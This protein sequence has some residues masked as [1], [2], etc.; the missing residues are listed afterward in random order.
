MITSSSSHRL[1]N[2]YVSKPIII[3]TYAFAKQAPGENGSSSTSS[4]SSFKWTVLIRSGDEESSC[5]EDKQHDL[6]EFIRR[7]EFN[8]HSTFAQPRRIVESP[9]FQ[10]EEQGWG[11]FEIIAR[12]FFHDTNEKPVDIKHWLKVRPDEHDIQA[13]KLDYTQQPLVHE[14]FEEIVFH[15]PHEWF[16]EKLTKP[17]SHAPL[18]SLDTAG[19]KT[20]MSRH[21]L[22]QWFKSVKEWKQEEEEMAKKLIEIDN[23]TRIQIANHQSQILLVDSDYRSYRDHFYKYNISN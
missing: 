11:E 20:P 21:P 18:I 6:S 23:F 14:Q 5:E 15:S 12:I 3:G 19:G 17:S 8:L 4:P 7:V 16:Y 10:V 22:R 1:L 9:P 2:T 13:S